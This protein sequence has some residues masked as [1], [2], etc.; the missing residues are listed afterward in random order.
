MHLI[1]KKLFISNF[2][3][4]LKVIEPEVKILAFELSFVSFPS[5]FPRTSQA[6]PKPRHVLKIAR[7]NPVNLFDQKRENMGLEC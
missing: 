4:H 1:R 3:A 7:Y 2:R 6:C 5:M